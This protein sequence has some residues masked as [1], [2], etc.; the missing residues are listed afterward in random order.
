MPDKADPY[1]NI[2]TLEKFTGVCFT[3][4]NLNNQYLRWELNLTNNEAW[5]IQQQ[6]KIVDLLRHKHRI[7]ESLRQ[8]DQMC[9]IARPDTFSYSG[10]RPAL[11]HLTMKSNILALRAGPAQTRFLES[12]HRLDFVI[13]IICHFIAN[14]GCSWMWRNIPSGLFKRAP[15]IGRKL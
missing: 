4:V 1:R 9:W 13:A 7:N 14:I 12:N 3:T 11:W 8:R 10:T 6:Q 15:S 5:R 2:H